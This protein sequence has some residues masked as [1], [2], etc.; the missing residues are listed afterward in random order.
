VILITG[1]NGVIGRSLIQ[2]LERENI[3]ATY[4]SRNGF[5]LEKKGVLGELCG[6]VPELIFHLAASV[7]K[8][9]QG[10]QAKINGD[11]TRKID[12]NV[13]DAATKWGAHVVYS[14]GCSLYA[15]GPGW[16][17]TPPNEDCLNE[18]AQLQI[19][20]ASPYLE[21]KRF[22]EELFSSLPK[23]TILRISAPVGPGLP[24]DAI[25]Q[26]LMWQLKSQGKIFLWGK[27]TREQNF[28]DVVDI[29]RAFVK[30]ATSNKTGTF[31]IAA[32]NPT[33][34]R[35]MASL[36]ENIVEKKCV[37]FVDIPDPQEGNKAHFCNKLARVELGWSPKV[38]L[39]ESVRQLWET[40]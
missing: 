24:K 36:L 25:V 7:P 39:A 38:T 34:M 21:A 32:D 13:F 12:E 11:K 27:G 33:T 3:A 9:N 15:K 26:K 28:I 29:A 20:N 18:Q 16:H 8:D 2:L 23:S 1:A 6:E 4:V 22:G 10:I 14:S 35:E 17:E 5:D 37:E 19:D 30:V 40:T 31:N